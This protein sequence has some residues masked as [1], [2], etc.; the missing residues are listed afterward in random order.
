[1]NTWPNTER[2]AADG[3]GIPASFPLQ[4]GTAVRV[5][6]AA[7]GPSQAQLWATPGV[8][9]GGREVM[10]A[11]RLKVEWAAQPDEGRWFKT[12]ELEAASVGVGRIAALHSVHPA[13]P[14]A[15]N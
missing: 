12:D 8:V 11:L 2:Q 9:A 4:L 15:R 14:G 5:T 3:G 10:G 1:M 6:K 13:A 7:V